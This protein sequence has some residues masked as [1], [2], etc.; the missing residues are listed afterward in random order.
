[1][2]AFQAEDRGSIPL[3]RSMKRPSKYTKIMGERVYIKLPTLKDA[4]K[5]LE[6]TQDEELKKYVTWKSPESLKGAELFIK[7][8]RLAIQKGEKFLGGVYLNENNELIGS[9]GRCR[10]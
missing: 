9:A 4:E 1:M 6:F 3:T 8:R 10:K 7:N 2:T 5:I